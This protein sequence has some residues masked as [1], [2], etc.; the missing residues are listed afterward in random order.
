MTNSR[1][2]VE[3][4][5]LSQVNNNERNFLTALNENL[6]RIQDAINDTL[7]RTGV[8]PNQMEEVLDMNG[9]RI[10]NVGPAVEP[11]DVVTKQD[12]Q[13]IIDAANEAITRLDGLVEAGKVALMNYAQEYI[14]PTVTAALDGAQLAQ[15]KAE[16]A[17]G[18]AEIAQGKAEDAQDAAEAARDALLLNAG[19]QAVVND[20]QTLEA[21]GADLTNID[22]VHAYLQDIDDIADHLTELH[23]I[24]GHLTE[25][26]AVEADLTNLDSIAADLTNLDSIASNLTEILNASTYA[27]QA[28]TSASNASTWAEGTDQQVSALGGTHSAKGWADYIE[29]LIAGTRIYGG[30]FVPSTATATLTSSAKTRLGTTSNTIVLTN[31]TTA[32]TGYA[33]NEGIEY[34]VT[35]NGT[36]ASIVLHEGD[37]LWS[38]GT[39]WKKI[40]NAATEIPDATESVKGIAAL[41]NGTEAVAG[42]N[43]TKIMTPLKTTQAINDYI[44]RGTGIPTSSTVGTI[45]QLYIDTTQTHTG[46]GNMTNLRGDTIYYCKTI[47]NVQGVDH[48]NWSLVPINIATA[49]TSLWLGSF[50]DGN[51]DGPYCVTLG[52]GTYSRGN[53]TTTIGGK[54]STYKDGSTTLLYSTAVGY[55]AV[56]SADSAISLGYNANA[57]AASAIQIGSGTNAVANSFQVHGYQVLDGSGH[58][59][60]ARL[61]STGDGTKYLKGDGT[62]YTPTLSDYA[63]AGT[64]ISLTDETGS[65]RKV[66]S[67]VAFTGAD[68]TNAGTLG[69]VPAPAATDDNKFLKGDGTW[70]T[71]AA[72]MDASYNASTGSVDFTSSSLGGSGVTPNYSQGS[73][74]TSGWTATASGLL[75]LRHVE[76][77]NVNVY[78]D[79]VLVYD[80]SWQGGDYGTQW[81]VTFMPVGVGSV[82]TFNNNYS[83]LTVTFYPYI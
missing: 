16:T 48:Y 51:I 72:G 73:T 57:T 50:Q 22:Q 56:S 38:T 47:N 6:K 71:A 29:E 7:S 13:N 10:C 83:T 80:H 23:T 5:T 44:I 31:D 58:I 34:Y 82:I 33:A 36:F 30:T 18:K 32:I 3:I 14:Y 52:M 81:Q 25:L 15:Q 59:P 60:L 64:G 79:N 4:N 62:W 42:S 75:K 24:Y 12:I 1:N 21:I 20:I 9:H 41:A 43:D 74:I 77:S 54:A 63:V 19:Y 26:L 40:D 46:S 69:A 66:I 78:V 2:K 68:G 45:G 49:N 76:Y 8:V 35:A 28:A 27:S 55:Q 61:G 17:Q 67:A 53:Y 11:T 39:A 37:I 65:T 70:S